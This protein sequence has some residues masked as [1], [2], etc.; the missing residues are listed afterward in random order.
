MPP[1]IR[2]NTPAIDDQ[3]ARYYSDLDAL[4]LLALNGR[5]NEG[6]FTEELTRLVLAMLLLAFAT[7]GGNQSLPGAAELLE[8]RRRQS[9]S[10]IAI[11]AD[12]IYSGRYSARTEAEPGRPVQ[13]ADEGL[14]KLRNRL[15]LWVNSAGAMYNESLIYQT[16]VLNP[17]T[18][19]MEEPLYAWILGPTEHCTDCLTFSG[20]I[21]PASEWRRL[22]R[23][24]DYQLE[25]RGFNCQCSYRQVSGDSAVTN[26][27]ELI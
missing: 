4:M 21:L 16:A 23:P 27:D 15:T 5:I 7:A 14:D 8:R 2:F 24:Q 20:F 9:L 1:Y 11:L 6:D 10:S 17:E 18:G 25:C 22:P 19:Q 26:L 13:T 3:L 12:D